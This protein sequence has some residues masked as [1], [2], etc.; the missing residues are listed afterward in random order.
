MCSVISPPRSR[1][2]R[3][4]SCAARHLDSPPPR[5]SRRRG[6]RCTSSRRWPIS[7]RGRDARARRLHLESGWER[8]L[9]PRAR[10]HCESRPALSVGARPLREVTLPTPRTEPV[11]DILVWDTRAR[12]ELVDS[13]LNFIELRAS[14]STKAAIA[15]AAKDFERR[16]R[17]QQPRA[18][19]CPRGMCAHPALSCV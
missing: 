19:R 17:G 14:A 6:S 18:P 16:R 5:S 7:L 10:S 8:Q 3:H 2:A 4:R 12:I 9:E 1:I 13:S 11:R 15:S